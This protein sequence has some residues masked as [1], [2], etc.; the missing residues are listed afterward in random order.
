[1]GIQSPQMEDRY[2]RYAAACCALRRRRLVGL[3]R[4]VDSVTFTAIP[5]VLATVALLACRIPARRA[6]RSRA[7]PPLPR[8]LEDRI[9]KPLGMTC[10]FVLTSADQK[11]ADVARGYD[12]SSG[13]DDFAGMAT[14][15]G[16]V[17]HR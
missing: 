3:R 16:G 6:T 7:T 8:F 9:F 17:F 5:V 11:T 4:P 1:M 14:G 15:D 10:T 13:D 2:E 12:R